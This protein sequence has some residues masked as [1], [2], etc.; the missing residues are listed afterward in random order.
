MFVKG[1]RYNW[2][3]QS[4][5]LVYLFKRGPWEC[6]ALVSAPDVI[7]CEVSP[8]LVGQIEETKE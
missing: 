3:G 1:K 2:I 7:W 8:D 5:R 6:F 4:E